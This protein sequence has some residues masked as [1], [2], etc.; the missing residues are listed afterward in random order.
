MANFGQTLRTAIGDARAAVT[1]ESPFSWDTVRTAMQTA[2]PNW[3]PGA[4]QQ[5]F[6]ERFHERFPNW[7]GGQWGQW[8]HHP[9]MGQ[10]RPQWTGEH[11]WQHQSPATAPTLPVTGSQGPQWDQQRALFDQQRQMLQDYKAQNPTVNV[12]LPRP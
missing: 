8:G 12:R 5:G 7:G 6:Q 2:Y 10:E 3:T 1:P 11:Q 4:F 9:W